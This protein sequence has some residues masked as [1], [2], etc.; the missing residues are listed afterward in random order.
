MGRAIGD[1][2]PVDGYF[3]WSLLDNFEWAEGIGPRFGLYAVD[4]ETFERRADLLETH[5][6]AR[7]CGLR[8]SDLEPLL[9]DGGIDAKKEQ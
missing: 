2:I 6:I 4:F 8:L 5:L 9:E 3:H 7:A 1:G